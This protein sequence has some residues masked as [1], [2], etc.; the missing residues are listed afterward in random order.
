MPHDTSAARTRVRRP[1]IHERLVDHE[2]AAATAQVLGKIEQSGPGVQPAV[3]IVGIAEDDQPGT[4][5]RVDLADRVDLVSG[6]GRGTGVLGIGRRDNGGAAWP[7]QPGDQGQ[8]NL[9]AR[10]GHDL[11]GGVSAIGARRGCRDCGGGS[12]LRQTGEQIGRKTRQRIGIGIDPGRE[13][14]EWFRCAR[15]QAPGGIE[16]AAMQ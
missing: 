11:V 10:R 16:I 4:S 3:G 12:R 1:D 2:Q 14:D 15:E 13:V 9:R 5:A 6:K 8:Q 7:D